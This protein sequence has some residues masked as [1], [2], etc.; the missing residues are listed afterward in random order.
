MARRNASLGT[1]GAK[2]MTALICEPLDFRDEEV[3]H[4]PP[5]P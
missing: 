4:R 3:S 5:S 2:S 1:L